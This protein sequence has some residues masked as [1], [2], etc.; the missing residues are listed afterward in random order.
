MKVIANLFKIVV[1]LALLSLPAT[2]W[3]KDTSTLRGPGAVDDVNDHD[4]M[5]SVKSLMCGMA[6]L[7]DTVLYT[8]I[9]RDSRTNS[10]V[11]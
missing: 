5:L 9:R 2:I 8:T 11:W 6:F 7:F 3:V 4:C 1:S 10:Y